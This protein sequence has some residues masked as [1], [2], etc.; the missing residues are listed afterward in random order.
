MLF[1]PVRH[2]GSVGKAAGA[3]TFSYVYA[4]L[5]GGLHADDEAGMQLPEQMQ[6]LW[7]SILKQSHREF[8]T[9]FLCNCFSL[10]EVLF[11]GK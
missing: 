6:N 11:S 3:V 5:F 1:A 2:S 8:Y 7:N 9:S 10:I 4:F